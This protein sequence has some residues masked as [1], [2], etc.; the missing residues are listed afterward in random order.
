MWNLNLTKLIAGELLLLIDYTFYSN[1]N[2]I[3]FLCYLCGIQT[4][5]I[6]SKLFFLINYTFLQ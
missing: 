4:I 6:A 5:L 1:L 3:N 2:S